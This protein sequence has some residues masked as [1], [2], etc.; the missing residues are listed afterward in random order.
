MKDIYELL[1]DIEISESDFKELNVTEF[2][3]N[4]LKE[5]L[6]KTIEKKKFK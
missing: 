2:E 3:K 5:S 4:K 1:N 6:N